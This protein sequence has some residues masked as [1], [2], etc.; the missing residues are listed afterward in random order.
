MRAGVG[1]LMIA[2]ATLAA[3][4]PAAALPAALQPDAQVGIAPQARAVQPPP[5]DLAKAESQP[6]IA[7]VKAAA[8]LLMDAGSGSVLISNGGQQRRAPASLT[9]IMTALIVLERSKLD[10]LVT[11]DQASLDALKDTESSTIGLQAGD[12]MTVKDLLYGLLLPSGNDAA[13]VLAKAV[14][15]SEKSFVE[16]MNKRAAELDL[17]HT[18]FDNPHGLDSRNQYS[19]AYDLA[20]LTRVAM[21]NATFREIVAT[22]RQ[23]VTISGDPYSS[24]N[25]NELLQLYPGADGVKIGYTD[26]AGETMIGSAV[27]D[28]RRLLV[29]VLGSNR[30]AADAMLLL[31][32]GF[33]LRAF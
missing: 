6:K 13:L 5:A 19:T 15:G 22:Q 3:C 31:D 17:T 4:G 20:R 27:R 23:P 18:H 9:K 14:A 26:L 30:R 25:Y 33:G 10:R 2:G 16:L 28:G 24:P 21:N 29:V 1:I 11:A 8:Y 7:E 32:R 12:R